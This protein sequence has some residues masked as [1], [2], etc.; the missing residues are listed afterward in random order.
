M[1]LNVFVSQ[2]C[3][4]HCK[5]CYSFSREEEKGKIV[6]TKELIDFLEFVYNSGCHRITLCGGDPLARKD[7]IELLEKIKEIGFSISMDTVGSPIIKDIVND[8]GIYIKKVDSQ[9]IAKLVDIIGIPIDGSNNEIFKLFRQTNTDILNNQLT[10]CKILNE[11]NAH[12]CINTVVH[13]G[14]LGDACELAKL[15]KR[16]DYISKWQIF[17]YE[18]LGKYGLKNRKLFEINDREFSDFQSEVLKVFDNDISKL[19]FKSSHNRKNAYMLIDNSGNAWI[20]SCE[21]MSLAEYSYILNENVIIGNITNQKDWCKICS[22]LDRE[23]Y[24]EQ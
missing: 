9:K 18:P 5:G 10:I 12:I 15:V 23:F 21:N 22:Y 16:L 17:Q 3:F 11:F 1:H 19:Q 8:E 7:I 20:P 6:P 24:S 4:V 14:N 13:K 2:S